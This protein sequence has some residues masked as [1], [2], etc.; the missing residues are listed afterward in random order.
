MAEEYDDDEECTC[1][2]EGAV[3]LRELHVIEY[4]MPDGTIEPINFS[5]DG[6]GLVLDVQGTLYL[7][8]WAK[9]DVMAP[10]HAMA[11][12]RLIEEG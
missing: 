6:A 9:S 12:T 11:I 2:P 5:N 4:M 10:I 1:V 8:E 3:A 7:A